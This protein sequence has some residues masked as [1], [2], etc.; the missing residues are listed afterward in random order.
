MIII[1]KQWNIIVGHK[2]LTVL[3]KISKQLIELWVAKWQY[4]LIKFSGIQ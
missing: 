3:D 2:K 1:I 4:N